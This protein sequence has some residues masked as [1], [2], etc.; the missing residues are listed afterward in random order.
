MRPPNAFSFGIFFYQRFV[1]LLPI[2]SDNIFFICVKFLYYSRAY[3]AYHLIPHS[4]TGKSPYRLLLYQQ[5]I[6]FYVMFY[7]ILIPLLIGSII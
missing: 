1:L 6:I 7:F 5:Q 2:L 3:L 4:L